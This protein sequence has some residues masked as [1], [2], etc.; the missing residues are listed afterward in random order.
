M[1]EVD[2]SIERVDYP[3]WN[4]VL[5]QIVLR[6]TFGVSL[7]ANEGMM[8]IGLLDRAMDVCFNVYKNP[9]SEM[10][11]LS[12]SRPHHHSRSALERL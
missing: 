12:T 10:S 3:C 4:F 8:W 11:Q 9:V 7:L 2:S 6:R 1:R 5:D